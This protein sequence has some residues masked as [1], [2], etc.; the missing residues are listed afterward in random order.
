MTKLFNYYGKDIEVSDEVYEFLIRDAW[1]QKKRK[2]R[3]TRCTIEGGARCTKSCS[4]CPYTQS[5][6]AFSLDYME[7]SGIG[8]S[9]GS[10]VESIVI[11][12]EFHSGLQDE[13]NVMDSMDKAILEL[14]Y[15]GKSDRQIAEELGMS[16]TTVSYKKRKLLTDLL[17]RFGEWL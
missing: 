10:S 12:E 9:D 15:D 5:G 16:Q 13:L 8:I 7:E 11:E 17:K 4:E 2:E 3:S 6:G 14:K 1:K